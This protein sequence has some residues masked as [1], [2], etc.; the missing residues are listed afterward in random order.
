MTEDTVRRPRH[1]AGG[2]WPFECIEL[3]RLLP[4]CD[5]NVVKYIWRHADKG[6]P[7]TDL[8]KAQVYLEWAAED[9]A[10]TSEE[11]REVRRLANMFT[12]EASVRSRAGDIHSGEYHAYLA[13]SGVAHRDYEYALTHLGVAIK[14]HEE[15]ANTTM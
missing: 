2:G 10:T 7:V 1:Y 14:I 6:D 5:G 9:R 12:T 15:D 3:T 11:Y 13:V 8:R 4:F